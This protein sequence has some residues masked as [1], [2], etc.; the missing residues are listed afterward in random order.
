MAKRTSSAVQRKPETPPL[1]PSTLGKFVSIELP[2]EAVA[3]LNEVMRITGDS[4]ESL[5]RKSL[6]LY[7]IA[8]DAGLEGNR[9]V[10]VDPEGE[11]V[12]D[13]TGF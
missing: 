13:I 6:G 1:E 4:T 10:V 12:Q 9:V 2:D 7:K 3:L 11:I 8:V 5:F